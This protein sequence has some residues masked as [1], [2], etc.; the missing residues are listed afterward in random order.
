MN[1]RLLAPL[2][3]SLG[4][5]LPGVSLGNPTQLYQ[6]TAHDAFYGLC[7]SEARQI[8]VG[9]AGLILETQD[10]G[11]SWTEVPPFTERAL[12]DVSCG[13]DVSLIVGQE[14]AIYR[15]TSEDYEA[16]IS[17]TNERLLSVSDVS[18]NGLVFAVGGFGTVLR[19][20][21]S[22]LNWT[23]LTPDWPTLTNDFFEPHLY[24]VHVSNAGVVTIVGEFEMVIQSTDQGDSWEAT[25]IGEAS[26]FGLSLHASGAGF[27]V[28]QNGKILK[29]ADGGQNWKQIDSP[30][31]SILLNVWTSGTG[32]VLVSGIRNMLQSS[33][34]GA[35]WA[36]IEQGDLSTGWYQGLS[37]I[38]AGSASGKFVLLAG[39]GGSLIKLKLDK[40]KN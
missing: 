1:F 26:L 10:A 36:Q 30:G 4:V 39:H 11:G 31:N 3:I 14:G 22:G 28:G 18:S 8:A 9:D 35:K 12:L 24:D 5:F 29:T 7:V 33:D 6:G 21:D 23:S 38:N 2:A 40:N 27:A 34:N 17:N 13:A 19:S 32:D 15:R 20:T 25:H 16:I 37:V